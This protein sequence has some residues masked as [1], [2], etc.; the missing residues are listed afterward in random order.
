[1]KLQDIIL[2]PDNPRIK[3]FEA[4]E[5]LKKSIIE[6]PQMMEL[7][8]IVIDENNMCIGGNRRCEALIEIHSSG[9]EYL[10]SYL[11]SI[12][13][14]ENYHYFE[15]LFSDGLLNINWV[16][17]RSDLSE[18]QKK[19]FIIK[20]NVSFARW[21]LEI[22]QNDFDINDLDSWNFNT[23]VFDLEITTKS[24]T[25]DETF[26]EELNQYNDSN[27]EMPIVPEFFEKHECFIIP[28]HNEI[29]ENF[30]R[31]IFNLNENHISASGDKKVRKT[32]V[33]KLES[34]RQWS[35]K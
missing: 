34:I 19:E 26:I 33:I 32:N 31:D 11:D 21:D 22:L 1:M 8:P 24:K 18:D 23:S 16:L 35:A 15:S 4:F 9:H 7:R 3:D 5:K 6:F 13:K 14:K 30:I 12:N 27:C 20:D 28:V 10:R 17:K 29:D 25:E 2:N